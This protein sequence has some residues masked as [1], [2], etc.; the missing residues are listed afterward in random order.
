MQGRTDPGHGAMNAEPADPMNAPAWPFVSVIL[1]A[2]NEAGHIEATLAAI[3]AGDYPADRFEVLVVD[4]A[5]RDATRALA[6]AVAARDTRVRVLDNPAGRTPVGL[7]I[8]LAE[9]RGE[10]IVRIDGHALPATDYL[11]ASVRALGR[12]GAWAVGGRLVGRGDTAFGRA[13]AAAT[14]SPFGAGDA[15]FRLGGEGPVDTVYLGA[16]PRAV[17]A[18][19]GGFDEALARN[20]DYELCLRIRAAGG[21]VWLDPAIRSTTL[22]RGAPGALARQYFGYGR[23]RA[24]TVKRHPGS[25]RWRQAVPALFVGALGLGS[26]AAAWSRAARGFVALLGGCYAVASLIAAARVGRG[27]AA[28]DAAWL[29]CVFWIVHVAWGLGFWAGAAQGR[30]PRDSRT[31]RIETASW[32]E[33]G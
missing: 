22:V 16:W 18:R 27:M 7:N 1:P 24:A 26:V 14:A 28:R 4:G 20:Q 6:L 3:L 33:L 13:V 11:R 9:A 21:T 12:S 31:G 10:V 15:R 8:G 23:G 30:D 29:P 25:L 17:F 32:C 2:R 5:S 19:V